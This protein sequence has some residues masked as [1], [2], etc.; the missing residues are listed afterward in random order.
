M[1]AYVILLLKAQT[2]AHPGGLFGCHDRS[3]CTAGTSH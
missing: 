3:L 2:E 1:T